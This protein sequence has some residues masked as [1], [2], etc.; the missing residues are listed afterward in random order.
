MKL[1]VTDMDGTFLN[2][3][4]E[5]TEYN[6]SAIEYAQS[7][8]V[9]F[10]IA[11]GRNY[12]TIQPMLER[13]HIRCSC[14]LLNGA[15]FR[16]KEGRVVKKT[17]I[18]YEKGAE[19]IRLLESQGFYPEI[20]SGDGFYSIYS[21]EQIK[22]GMLGRMRCLHPYA[23]EA[24]LEELMLDSIFYQELQ[25]ADSLNALEQQGVELLK[26]IVFHQDRKLIEE[27]KE[28]IHQLGNLTASSS[29]PNNI[30]INDIHAQKGIALT[31][32]VQ[33]QGIEKEE[34]MVFGDGLN[35]YSLF[36]EFP[37]SFAPVN[38]MKEIREIA[39]TIIESNN[40]DGVGKTIFRCLK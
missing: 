13:Y 36:T 38:A 2:Q 11:T 20:M 15:E 32:Y 28:R 4:Q 16:D 19:L 39:G 25:Y 3:N 34:V 1:I 8:G 18:S 14:M 30:E 22:P 33:E 23:S 24:E 12:I 21:K 40:E 37:H 26:L 10:M 29:F 7:K 17:P 6:R 9:E 31:E 35:D 27:T 5:I